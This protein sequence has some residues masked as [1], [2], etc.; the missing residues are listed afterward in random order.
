MKNQTT[1]NDPAIIRA[2]KKLLK[3]K[4]TPAYVYC[5]KKLREQANLLLNM[6]IGHE[7]R[8]RYAIKAN[9][10]RNIIKLFD[11]LGL[12][13]DASSEYE[14]QRLLKIG[15]AGEKI[16]LTA[17]QL[18]KNPEK[19]LKEKVILNACSLHQLDIYARLTAKLGTA[20]SLRFN[21][22][23][24]HDVPFKTNV[25]GPNSSFGI[26]HEHLDKA[27]A[28]IKKSRAKLERL[29]LHVGSGTNDETWIKTAQMGIAIL[30]RCKSVSTIN[31]GGGL[32]I[33]RLNNK[34][35][36]LDKIAKSV[37]KYLA[38]FEKKTG[39][40]IKVEI[41]PGTF[42]VAKAGCLL[43]QIDDLCDTGRNGYHFIKL[44]GGMNDYLRPSLY[45]AQHRITHLQKTPQKSKKSPAKSYVLVGHCCENGDILSP[46]NQQN[47]FSQ[48][49]FSSEP[50]IG[51]GI[52]FH[53]T[54][55]YGASMANNYNSYPLAPEYWLGSN[56][57][58]SI[59]RKRQKVEEVFSLETNLFS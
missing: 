45:H 58:L 12:H 46:G 16:M 25:S 23:S 37:N 28:I 52:I 18:A 39:R 43:L 34:M 54:G 56:K 40:S 21:P 19:L 35:A 10:N 50:Q 32:R 14:A 9:S 57:K 4:Q 33:D 42:I 49:K 11:N 5:E 47:P 44:D 48:V 15:I 20:L 36:N 17:Q 53:D 29:H 22:G 41:E 55:A 26:W 38:D 3:E 59:I 1:T 2:C 13:F 31:L 30:E 7:H 6:P 27:F 51:D 24:E 8:V